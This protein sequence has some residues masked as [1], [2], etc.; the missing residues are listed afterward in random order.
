MLIDFK[1]ISSSFT[2]MSDLSRWLFVFY[3]DDI[4][5]WIAAW[6]ISKPSHDPTDSVGSDCLS[7]RTCM[8]GAIQPVLVVDILLFFFFN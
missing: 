5:I 3:R 2:G 4:I 1:G 8:R 6:K 7:Y